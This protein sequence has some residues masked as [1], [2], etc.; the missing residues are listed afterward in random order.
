MSK[1]GGNPKQYQTRLTV[2]QMTINHN[3][4]GKKEELTKVI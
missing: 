3:R 4:S 2:E 1:C